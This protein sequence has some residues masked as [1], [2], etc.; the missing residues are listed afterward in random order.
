MKTINIAI[1][2]PAGAG[3]SSI[4]REVSSELGFI[5]VDTG[6]LYRAIAY[7]ALEHQLTSETALVRQLKKLTW[8]SNTSAAIS[9]S[10]ST[11]RTSPMK[12]VRR[13]SQKWHPRSL[14]I[15]LFGNFCLTCSKNLP[16]NTMSSWTAETSVLLYCRMQ[17]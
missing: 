10:P 13:K 9:V 17:T 14:L 7:Y 5:Y 4:A 3:K 15:Q 16:R 6:A 8:I 1:D 11:E 2:G 12:S